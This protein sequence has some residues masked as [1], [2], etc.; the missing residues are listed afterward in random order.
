MYDVRQLLF[1][2][3]AILRTHVYVCVFL[4]K[5]DCEQQSHRIDRQDGLQRPVAD[6]HSSL[7]RRHRKAVTIR[8][9][10]TYPTGHVIHTLKICI[11]S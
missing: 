2:S 3:P 11:Y 8:T 5:T 1:L 6:F 10:K 4:D 7:H 9:G